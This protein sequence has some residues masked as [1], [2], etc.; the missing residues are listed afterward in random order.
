MARKG[1][2]PVVIRGDWGRGRL[3]AA[4]ET[5]PSGGEAY[6]LWPVRRRP[7]VGGLLFGQG[8][9]AGGLLPDLGSGNGLSRALDQAKEVGRGEEVTGNGSQGRACH[10][11]ARQM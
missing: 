9:P 8:G 7:V 4:Q 1:G 2:D 6:K 5:Q 10:A 11:E 3:Q